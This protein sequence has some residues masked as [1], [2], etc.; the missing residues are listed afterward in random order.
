MTVYEVPYTQQIY[1]YWYGK[2]QIEKELGEMVKKGRRNRE[3]VECQLGCGLIL[4]RSARGM[5]EEHSCPNRLAPCRKGCGSFFMLHQVSI[6]FSFCDDT[7][8]IFHVRYRM[9]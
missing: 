8:F 6:I 7:F 1:N 5:H 3:H 2:K 9:T 4:P